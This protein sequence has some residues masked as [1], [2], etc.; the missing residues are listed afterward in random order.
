[1]PRS[2]PNQHLSRD[3]LCRDQVWILWHIPCTVHLAWMVD[4]LRDLDVRLL[5][6]DRVSPELTTLIIIGGAV[7]A[8][9]RST[10]CA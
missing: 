7:E 4:S 6:G 1:M 9:G 2:I 8:V 5:G 10:A 3:R